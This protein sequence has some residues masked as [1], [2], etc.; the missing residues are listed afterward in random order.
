MKAHCCRTI[1]KL[2]ISAAKGIGPYKTSF[3]LPHF[4]NELRV[5]SVSAYS[6]DLT[7]LVTPPTDFR[8]KEIQWVPL[9]KNLANPREVLWVLA[10]G[11]TFTYE[12][13]HRRGNHGPHFLIIHLSCLV[14]CGTLSHSSP[15]NFP[16]LVVLPFLYVKKKRE[17]EFKSCHALVLTVLS[18]LD[19][20]MITV[21]SGPTFTIVFERQRSAGLRA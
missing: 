4:S 15:G 12:R 7:F 16:F 20:H 8:K 9:E 6:S 18:G 19:G 17:R 3:C 21:S 1:W 13:Q 5:S 14:G 11:F 10:I 2:Y